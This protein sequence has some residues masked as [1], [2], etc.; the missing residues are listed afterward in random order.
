MHL[1]IE[2][3]TL[4]KHFDMQR[5]KKQHFKTEQRYLH[6]LAAKKVHVAYNIM[7]K[8]TINL[9]RQFITMAM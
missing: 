5:L 1:Q 6:Q 4:E 8:S 2:Q 3:M 7:S 9:Q